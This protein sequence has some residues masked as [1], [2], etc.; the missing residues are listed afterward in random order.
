MILILNAY[1][2]I[3]KFLDCSEQ[4]FKSYEG[5]DRFYIIMFHWIIEVSDID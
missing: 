4:C 5:S 1:K 2:H 3:L